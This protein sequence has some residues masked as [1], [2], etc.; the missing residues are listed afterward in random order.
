[1]PFWN[2]YPYTNFH[3][4][5]LDWILKV[6]RELV[7][8]FDHD[9]SQAM[10]EYI[11]EHLGDFIAEAAYNQ[12]DELITLSDTDTPSAIG[13]YVSAFNIGDETSALIKVKDASA[14]HFADMNGGSKDVTITAV[15][16]PD[17]SDYGDN[18]LI[19][20]GEKT[21]MVDM[22]NNIDY[23]I[24]Y[25]QSEGIIHI[26][27]IIMT[28]WHLDHCGGGTYSPADYGF[29]DLFADP[30][31]DW[32]G[33]VCYLPH[34][35][36]DISL[37]T[38]ATLQAHISD[39][40]NAF[41]LAAVAAGCQ[42]VFPI[43]GQQVVFSDQVKAEFH[44]IGSTFYSNYY[45]NFVG[46]DGALG[47]KTIYNNFSMITVM[48]ILGK[49]AVFTG[50][51]NKLAEDLNAEI[52]HGAYFMTIPHHGVNTYCSD[53]FISA[54]NSS[55]AVIGQRASSP[56]IGTYDTER[57]NAIGGQVYDTYYGAQNF[58]FTPGGIIPSGQPMLIG[59]ADYYSGNVLP[60]GA[61]LNDY[62]LPGTY[63]CPDATRAAAI[64]NGPIWMYSGHEDWSYRLDVIDTKR[65]A[66]NVIQICTMA[67]TTVAEMVMRV[68]DSSNNWTDW[69][70][71]GGNVNMNNRIVKTADV[72]ITGE[73]NTPATPRRGFNYYAGMATV[74]MEF[75]AN[76]D[77]T[78]NGDIITLTGINITPYYGRP[79]FTDLGSDNTVRGFYAR[80]SGSDVVIG[81]RQAIPNG[82]TVRV[83]LTFRC[84]R[85]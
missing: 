47:T 21:Y 39:V 15:K 29:M 57:I 58:Q 53:A 18:F 26:D 82:T 4:L 23:L 14:V 30:S 8:K 46:S 10:Q 69:L 12:V 34:G 81:C 27:K 42:C 68:K 5:N 28:H 11:Q 65:I 67:N 61:D 35:G 38:D 85:T 79:W 7:E 49:A 2:R 41:Q 31:F 9:M 76:E 73:T 22:G 84:N 25:L 74:N 48:N 36:M 55:Y 60:D 62:V 13:G 54:L 37:V 70:L 71:M 80:N 3:E 33:T 50:D 24:S 52:I 16:D 32:T 17:I 66:D 6:L 77:I 1:M 20:D 72:T 83:S 63:Y 78:A 45:N 59:H 43:E 44:N 75:T 40:E 19:R 56:H 51:I 64:T